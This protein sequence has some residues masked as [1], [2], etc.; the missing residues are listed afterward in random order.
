MNK[1]NQS[2]DVLRGIAI[3]LVMLHHFPMRPGNLLDSVGWCGVDLF[4]VLSGFLISGLLF[5]EYAA[6]GTID[7]KRFLLRRGM[8][9]WPAFYVYLTI[10]AIPILYLRDWKSVAA[11]ALFVTNFQLH[12]AGALDHIWSLSV[13]EHFY[14]LLPLLL[15]FLVKRN[16]IGLVPW[17]AGIVAIVSFSLRVLISGVPASRLSFCRFDS[18]FAG[19]LLSY[20]YHCSPDHFRWI[21]RTRNLAI[22]AVIVPAAFLGPELFRRTFGFTF[23]AIGFS[24]VLAWSVDRRPRTLAGRSS[25]A[26]LARVGFYSY[27]IYLWHQ[28]LT[29]AYLGQQL[30]IVKIAALC[31]ISIVVGV[32][33]AR[34]IEIPILRIRDRIL[35]SHHEIVLTPNSAAFT[36]ETVHAADVF[37]S[38]SNSPIRY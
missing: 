24:I 28:P 8:K 32:V 30:S 25:S 3:L 27:S 18:L 6:S 12:V 17:I 35:P 11:S 4:F 14:L 36:P 13:E 19:V 10:L 34:I 29:T 9:I 21:S 37:G 23:L 15:F 2:L 1:R 31:A 16:R 26:V 33:M 38:V 20:L 5:R 7:V 22:A